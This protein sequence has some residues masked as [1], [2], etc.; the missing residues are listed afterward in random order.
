[1]S[2][3]CRVWLSRLAAAK[4][5]VG[6]MAMDINP[7]FLITGRQP[8]FEKKRRLLIEDQG[9]SSKAAM[10]QAY[11][12]AVNCARDVKWHGSIGIKEK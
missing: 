1:L 5:R 9:K 7:Y 3:V 4:I 10:E 12:R 6:I 11:E 2:L 8:M